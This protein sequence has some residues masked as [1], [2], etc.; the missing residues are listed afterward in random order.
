MAN[1]HLNIS[2]GKVGK[3]GPHIDYI[4]GQNKY[5]NKENE[6]KYTNH[7]LPN[8]C[9]SPKEFWVASDE[10]E[11]INGTVYK[12]IRISLPNELTEDKNIELLNEFLDTILE[13][14][15]HYSVAIH[16]KESSYKKEILNTHAHIMFSPRELDGIERNK[17][18]FFKRANTKSPERGG[19][20]KNTEWNNIEKLLE[21]RKIW[22]EMQN[23]YLENAN[24]N[25]RVSCET[26]EKQR[27]IALEKGDHLLAESLDRNPIHINGALLK[28]PEEK[29]SEDHRN[30][31]ESFKLNREIKELKDEILKL[32]RLEAEKSLKKDAIKEI[33]LELN[34]FSDSKYQDILDTH[35]KLEGINIQ[36]LKVEYELLSSFNMEKNR[37]DSLNLLLKNLNNDKLN[38]EKYLDQFEETIQENEFKVYAEEKLKNSFNTMFNI[39]NQ[40]NYEIKKA[41]KIL[42]NIPRQL[43][44]LETTSLNILTKGEYSKLKRQLDSNELNLMRYESGY[45]YKDGS[46]KKLNFFKNEI[47]RLSESNKVILSQI[48]KIKSDYS[49]PEMKNKKIKIEKSIESKLLK[50]KEL[51]ESILLDRKITALILH[52]KLIKVDSSIFECYLSNEESKR[53]KS[54]L[55]ASKLSEIYS[56]FKDM[57]FENIENLALNSLSKGRY[58]KAMKEYRVLD[59]KRIELQIERD[60]YTTFSKKLLHLGS[61]SRVNRELKSVNN[62]LLK[63]EKEFKEIQKSIG[64]KKLHEEISRINSLRDSI[65]KRYSKQSDMYREQSN[66]NEF[67][68]KETKNLK[69]ELDLEKDISNRFTKTSLKSNY[70]N[71]RGKIL[72]NYL[73]DFEIEKKKRKSFSMDF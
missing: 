18:I 31:L 40:S 72:G 19:C 55:R 5:T 52:K 1:Y 37:L 32:E 50:E 36:I 56:Y 59:N 67:F 68:I 57:K 39:F 17:D 20:K 23:K 35:E 54:S 63:L 27:E 73:V 34:S 10:K 3:G 33:D 46:E 61:L 4:L 26:L 49:T 16:S 48:E 21:I 8:W 14:K 11:R 22:E 66:L 58:F 60:S 38:L 7:N 71:L 2:Y 25:E 13:G 64:D 69:R 15:Y 6:I 12:E 47:E 24:V 43:K 9:K 70:L 30:K 42:K 53:L 45:K 41:E 29:L 28:K 51:Q 62:S 44:N 65:A